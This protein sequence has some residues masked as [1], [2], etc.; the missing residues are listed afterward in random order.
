M[1]LKRVCKYKYYFIKEC[2]NVMIEVPVDYTTEDIDAM[3][4]ASKSYFKR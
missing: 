3:I 1:E 4:L 2:K